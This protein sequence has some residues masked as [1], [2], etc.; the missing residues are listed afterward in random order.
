MAP[1]P[2]KHS[3][4]KGKARLYMCSTCGVRHESP[5]GARCQRQRLNE[6]PAQPHDAPQ[7]SA[8][9]PATS[10]RETPKKRRRTARCDPPEQPERDTFLTAASEDESMGD[11]LVRLNRDDNDVLPPSGAIRQQVSPVASTPSTAPI[12]GTSQQVNGDS[13]DRAPVTKDMFAMLCEQIAILADTQTREREK[14]QQES[15]D[16]IAALRTTIANMA[17]RIASC[18]HANNIADGRDRLVNTREMQPPDSSQVPT[19]SDPAQAKLVPTG[20]TTQALLEACNEGASTSGQ[21]TPAQLAQSEDPVRTLRR[22][23]PTATDAAAILRE[24]ALIDSGSRRKKGGHNSKH[25]VSQIEADWPDLYVYRVGNADPT[26][27]SLSLAEFVAGYLS[28]MEEVTP[29][30]PSNARL[31]RH[32]P[33]L[34]QLM[35]D[36]FLAEWEVVKMAHKQVLLS[37]EHKRIDWDNTALVLD[38][39]RMALARIQQSALAG[40]PPQHLSTS[41]G[42]VAALFR[43]PCATIIKI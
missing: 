15:R 32:L 17:G 22:H 35:E 6:A 23:R 14:A 5:T 1:D 29:L 38:T 36:S 43:P 30:L 37:I 24:I 31:L 41:G 13:E 16:S 33:Y 18:E 12:A 34:R 9:F 4:R 42:G 20:N 40:R 19:T 2:K 28:I 7:S 21:I 8:G 3:A 27:D 10:P 39:K 11:F 26:Y 25:S